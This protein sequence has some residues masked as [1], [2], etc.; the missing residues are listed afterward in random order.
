MKRFITAILLIAASAISADA[1][2]D[3]SIFSPFQWRRAGPRW[4]IRMRPRSAKSATYTR[5]GLDG[6]ELVEN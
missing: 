3:P 4:G 2:L 5:S 1:P 6:P